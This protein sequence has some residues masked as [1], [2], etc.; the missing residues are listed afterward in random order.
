MKQH[1]LLLLVIIP[2][3]TFAQNPTED[4]LRA[5]EQESKQQ[6]VDRKALYSGGMLLFQ[7][8]YTMASNDL[9]DIK[10]SSMAIG[11]ILRFYLG[12]YVA[13]GIYGA[14]QKTTYPTAN[15]IQSYFNLGY[16]GPF[17]GITRQSGNY[18]YTLSAFAGMG[19]IK[20]LH[21]EQQNQ[22]TL[23]ESYLYQHSFFV[24]SPM[25]SLDYALTKKLSLTFQAI[26]L[27]GRYDGGKRLFNPTMQAGI[28]FNR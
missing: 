28:L 21:I 25:L 4:A 22:E 24:Y 12:K 13:T 26:C 6:L 14:S 15:S 1:L 19:S 7:P 5:L 2:L 17:L 11:G 10:A 9:Q 23:T 20:N 18:R 16:G 8:G 3:L 27:M